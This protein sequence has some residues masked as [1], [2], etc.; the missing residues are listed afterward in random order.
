MISHIHIGTSNLLRAVEFYDA[1]L[2]PLNIR[3]KFVDDENGWAGWKCEVADRPLFLVGRPFNG[4]QS[5][6]GNG[7]MVAL[8]SPSRR[9]VDVCHAIAL[10]AGATDEGQPGLRLN[11]HSDYYGAY[12]RDLDDNKICICCHEAE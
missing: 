9:T 5:S 1:V 10:R 2:N 12:F 7:A 3:R 8:L 11:Y 6:A 4:A